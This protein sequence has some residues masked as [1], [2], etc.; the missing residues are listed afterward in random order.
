MSVKKSYRSNIIAFVTLG[1]AVAVFFVGP[2]F[3]QSGDAD[4]IAKLITKVNKEKKIPKEIKADILEQL[5]IDMKFTKQHKDDIALWTNGPKLP[6][7]SWFAFLIILIGWCVPLVIKYYENKN[8]PKQ[9][10]PG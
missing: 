8:L 7:V 5:K 2:Y 3:V 9:P 10:Q 4:D 6:V 1:V